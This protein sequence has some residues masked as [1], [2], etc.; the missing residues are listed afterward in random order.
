MS[1]TLNA[2]FKGFGNLISKGK[3]RL[4]A[5][6]DEGDSYGGVGDAEGVLRHAYVSDSDCTY[7]SNLY[8]ASLKTTNVNI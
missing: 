6:G 4:I 1:K 3:L 7:K 5:G 2:R 8:W